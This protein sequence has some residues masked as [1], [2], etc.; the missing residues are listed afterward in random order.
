MARFS[1]HFDT[2]PEDY[3]RGRAGHLQRRRVEAILASIDARRAGCVA[4]LGCG[5]GA[6]LRAVAAERPLLDFDGFDIDER[7][8]GFATE[9]NRLP[10]T[11]YAFADVATEVLPRQYDMLF[12]IDTIHHLHDHRLAFG[13]IRAGLRPMGTWLAIEPN[14]WHPYVTLQQERMR[15]AGLDEDHFRPWRLVPLLEASGF[16]VTSRRYLHAV[17]GGIDAVPRPVRRI[18][19]SV[20]RL[21][22]VG[23]SIVLELT[24]VV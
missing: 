9:T 3:E 2:A 12:S 19:R 24:A 8:L 5:T 23:A 18:E 16:R 11:A 20:E 15:R 14:I 1:S 7:L 6:V 10:N 13:S 21:P 4:E 17:P 22:V